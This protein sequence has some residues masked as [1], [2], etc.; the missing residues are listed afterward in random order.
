MD[1]IGFELL[2]AELCS[3]HQCFFYTNINQPISFHVALLGGICS[4]VRASVSYSYPSLHW[5]AQTIIFTKSKFKLKE[6]RKRGIL[7]TKC[8]LVELLLL[9]IESS[10]KATKINLEASLFFLGSFAN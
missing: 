8:L 7:T 5:F 2:K 10:R 1:Q 4:S 6:P 9:L 3:A